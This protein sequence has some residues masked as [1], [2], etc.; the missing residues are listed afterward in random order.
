MCYR[1]KK[2]CVVN[3][4]LSVA[5]HQ[6]DGLEQ[7]WKLGDT[8]VTNQRRMLSAIDGMTSTLA[9]RIAN[10]SS[11][12]RNFVST[13]LNRANTYVERRTTLLPNDSKQKIW[14]RLEHSQE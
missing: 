1:V 7:M 5:R 14:K 3:A 9:G 8:R 10:L 11:S 2:L 6:I 4:N 12:P 13:S